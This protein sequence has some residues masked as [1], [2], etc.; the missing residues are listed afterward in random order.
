MRHEEQLWFHWWRKMRRKSPYFSNNPR[1]DQAN[2]ARPKW[3][4]TLKYY[5]THWPLV[6]PNKILDNQFQN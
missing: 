5:L 2:G 3:V 1:G 6:D 4:N